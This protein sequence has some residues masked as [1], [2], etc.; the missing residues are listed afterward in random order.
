MSAQDHWVGEVVNHVCSFVPK[1]KWFSNREDANVWVSA[2]RVYR[3]PSDIVSLSKPLIANFEQVRAVFL[4]WNAPYQK[5]EQKV[6]EQKDG[7]IK[8]Q[9]H[10]LRVYWTGDGVLLL[11]IAPLP[12]NYGGNDQQAARERVSFIRSVMV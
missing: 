9:A 11:L 4:R 1:Q 10:P 5:L 6:I 2:Y 8:F 3:V 7:R 12:D